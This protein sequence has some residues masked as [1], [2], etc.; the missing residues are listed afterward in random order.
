MTTSGQRD[1]G[2]L[3]ALKFRRRT[4]STNLDVGS[5]QNGETDQGVNDLGDLRG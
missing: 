4:R 2:I 5:K 1:S 3:L